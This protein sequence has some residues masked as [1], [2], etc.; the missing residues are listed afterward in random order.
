MS[1]RSFEEDYIVMAC[2]A[3]AYIVMAYIVMVVICVCVCAFVCCSF[4]VFFFFAFHKSLLFCKWWCLENE[5]VPQSNLS[6]TKNQWP[7]CVS[8]VFAQNL[9]WDFSPKRRAFFENFTFRHKSE[10]KKERFAKNMRHTK[11]LPPLY[12]SKTGKPQIKKRTTT[13]YWKQ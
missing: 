2:I 8:A 10:A 7:M 12:F 9:E 6:W 4:C 11:I 5:V 13:K 3:M 1:S